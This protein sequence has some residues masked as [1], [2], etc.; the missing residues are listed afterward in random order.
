MK[1]G[2]YSAS[3]HLLQIAPAAERPSG[4]AAAQRPGCCPSPQQLGEAWRSQSPAAT[5]Q[6]QRLHS[7][8]N[9]TRSRCLNFQAAATLVESPPLGFEF[10]LSICQTSAS[11]ES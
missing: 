4:R 3:G 7:S 10:A 1:Q 5:E 8:N 11:I 6:K 2:T 9:T